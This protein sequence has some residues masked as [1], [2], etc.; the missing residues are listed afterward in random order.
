MK[1]IMAATVVN[2]GILASGPGKPR[3][4]ARLVTPEA[5][6]AMP[7]IKH[8]VHHHALEE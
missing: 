3:Q 7:R 1:R 2:I 8:V 4:S 5:C 6:S